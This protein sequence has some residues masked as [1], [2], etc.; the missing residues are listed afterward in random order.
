MQHTIKH[1]KFLHNHSIDSCLCWPKNG[2]Y[3]HAGCVCDV[4]LCLCNSCTSAHLHLVGNVCLHTM[5]PI[6]MTT[7]AWLHCLP[8]LDTS[9]QNAHSQDCT[10]TITAIRLLEAGNQFN[11]TLSY[12]NIHYYY[13]LLLLDLLLKSEA[14]I[15]TSA[16]V[17]LKRKWSMPLVHVTD[18][19]WFT[20]NA[21]SRAELKLMNT[22]N[23]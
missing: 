8:I 10:E 5:S 4:I 21:Q 9:M 19:S 15:C 17:I 23:K 16:T 2:Y 1:A 22:A 6:I 11:F 18:Q 13:K 20:D 3:G 7:P 14:C 12:W